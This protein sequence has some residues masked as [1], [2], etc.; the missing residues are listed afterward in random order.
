[1]ID[2]WPRDNRRV[3]FPWHVSRVNRDRCPTI[4]DADN[5]VVCLLTSGTLEDAE[6]IVRRCNADAE[7]REMT[8]V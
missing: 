6:R 7:A 2:H 4:V 8:E 3:R 1:M 5:K